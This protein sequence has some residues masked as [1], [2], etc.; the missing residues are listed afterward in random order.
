M[1]HKTTVTKRPKQV[2]Q[3]FQAFPIGDMDMNAV[4][5]SVGFFS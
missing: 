1:W 3:F 2:V 4:V 5:E